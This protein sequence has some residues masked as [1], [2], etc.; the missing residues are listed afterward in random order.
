MSSPQL[1]PQLDVEG[2]YG[3]ATTVDFVSGHLSIIDIDPPEEA[4][5]ITDFELPG[6][7]SI[8]VHGQYAYVSGGGGLQI[9][10]VSNPDTPVVVN[11]VP[12]G[13][14]SGLV[15]SGGYV[16]GGGGTSGLVIVDVDP[17]ESAFVLT[18]VPTPGNAG[19]VAVS[20][21]YAYVIDDA[22][23]LRIIKLW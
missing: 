10:D 23:G 19:A 14:G 13:G 5:D 21:G 4:H 18:T 11:V 2:G 17:S 9:I 6:A 22:T 12:G 7:G 15:Y 8:V 3:Y 20:D 1:F 16:Y